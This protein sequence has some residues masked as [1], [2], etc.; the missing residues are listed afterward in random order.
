VLTQT[1]HRQRQGAI[2]DELFDLVAG[3]EA[4]GGAAPAT[5]KPKRANTQ[6]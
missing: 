3:F 2:D 4:Q 1:F 5:H 6:T